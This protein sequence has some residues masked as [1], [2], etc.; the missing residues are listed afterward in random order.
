MSRAREEAFVYIVVDDVSQAKGDLAQDWSHDRRQH[1]ALDAGTPSSSVADLEHAPEAPSR[2]QAVIR[3]ARLRAERDALASAIPTDV[4]NRLSDARRELAVL[5]ARRHDLET[6]GPAYWHTPEGTAGAAVHRLAERIDAEHRRA[7]DPHASR[8]ER[9]TARY[10]IRDLT[11][12]LDDAMGHWKVVAGPEHARLI[13]Q[14]DRLGDAVDTLWQQHDHRI[15]WLERHPEALRRLDRLDRELDAYRAHSVERVA[16]RAIR[17]E[18][19]SL[20]VG[21]EIR[22]PDLGLSL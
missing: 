18:P 20:Q 9:R 12:Q 17:H 15:D 21:P 10:E 19:P 13:A 6:G 4:T 3:E 8:S 22:G 5:E 16:N 2:L 14:I 1:W 11:P 7:E